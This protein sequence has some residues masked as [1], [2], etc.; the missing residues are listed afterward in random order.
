MKAAMKT[1]Q[2]LERHF[3]SEEENSPMKVTQ[4]KMP[5]PRY[6][7]KSS[8]RSFKAHDTLDSGNNST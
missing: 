6:V 3:S 7:L 8:E 4:P 1:S 2:K 5:S